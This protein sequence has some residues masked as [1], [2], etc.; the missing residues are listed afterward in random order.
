IEA[1]GTANEL[2]W[3]GQMGQ[4]VGV[5]PYLQRRESLDQRAAP[6]GVVEV[7]VRQE[8]RPWFSVQRGQE[9]IQAARRAWIDKH[10]SE[11]PAADY[12]FPAEV[13]QIDQRGVGRRDHAPKLTRQTRPV[14]QPA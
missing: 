9:G 14:L 10:S 12:P 7:N 4:P 11:I 3:I 2:G 6:P 5:N 13:V 1:P 8:H